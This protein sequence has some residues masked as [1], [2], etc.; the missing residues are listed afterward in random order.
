MIRPLVAASCFLLST[1]C[2]LDDPELASAN[3]AIVGGYNIVHSPAVAALYLDT[4]DGPA[5]LCTGTL[6]S[7]HVV[8]TAA[9]CV[10]AVRPGEVLKVYFGS[11][12]RLSADPHFIDSVEVVEM[13]IDPD[14]SARGP[15]DD[16]G[17]DGSDIG[18]LRLAWAAK[19]KPVPF[20]RQ[21]LSNALDT[22]M[23]V[24]GFGLSDGTSGRDTS[25][26]K[27]EATVYVDQVTAGLIY[28]GVP[29]EGRPN[30][31]TCN[32]DSGGPSFINNGG[33][34]ELAG[35][36]S[37]GDPECLDFGANTRVDIHVQMIDAFVAAAESAAGSGPDEGSCPTGEPCDGESEGSGG[38]SGGAASTEPES[39]PRSAAGCST[40][41]GASVQWW[42][43]LF[44]VAMRL[45]CV[46]RLT[47]TAAS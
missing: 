12:L 35:V 9:H 27:R 1:G 14:W 37:F 7:P 8:A 4:P 3:H 31:N 47:A 22:P 2:G 10:E 24:V 16:F 43:L 44:L 36:T 42:F 21:P 23:R 38:T 13:T 25:G 46:A 40:S 5:T 19:V 32:G 15:A 29:V 34:E 28:Y 45:R 20:R 18:L 17:P 30:T 11:D 41:N 26:V 39:G 6:I 33:V